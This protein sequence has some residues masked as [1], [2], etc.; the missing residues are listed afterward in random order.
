MEA[1]WAARVCDRHMKKRKKKGKFKMRI[2]L[3]PEV[4]REYMETKSR[5]K[6]I[7][8]AKLYD[9]KKSIDP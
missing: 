2:R 4:L 3:S 1:G 9:R 6:K 8:S 5:A 7:P